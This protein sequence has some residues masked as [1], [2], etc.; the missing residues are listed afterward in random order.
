MDVR[1]RYPLAEQVGVEGYYIRINPSGVPTCDLK[2]QFLKINNLPDDKAEV[3]VT[4][5]VSVDALAL[6]RFGLRAAD[7]PRILNTIK[8]I[9]AVLKVDTPTG[10]CWYR[11][12]HDGYGEHEDGSPFDGTGIG[13][14][15]PLLTGERA[16]YEIAAGNLKG[17]RK[18]LETMESFANHGLF[19]EQ[20]W[21]A[22]DLPERELFFGKFSGSAMPL[23]WA[24][25]EYIKLCCSIKE[26]KVFD[27][28]QPV[29]ARYVE[30]KQESAQVAW[31]FTQPI[32]TLPVGRGLRIETRAAAMIHWTADNWE[33][34]KKISTRDT[35]LGIYFADLP[36]RKKKSG[37]IEFTFYWE[38]AECWE[39]KDFTVEIV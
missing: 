10:P 23:V 17:A 31:R 18:L 29:Y 15:W 35:G 39:G 12:N 9:D 4:E 38:E 33:T 26:K 37:R 34:S 36:V 21:D 30:N 6:V 27:L 25:A 1:D 7:D 2:G 22:D 28:P 14:A 16:H 20:I 11:Y 3:L 19:P 24:H 8:V 32:T 13:R 5:L